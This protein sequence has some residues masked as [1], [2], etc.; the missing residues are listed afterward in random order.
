MERYANLS[1]EQI[2]IFLM[3]AKLENFSR[4]AAALNLT[5]SAVSKNIQVIENTTGLILF[6]RHQKRVRLTRAGEYLAKELEQLNNQAHMIF[7]SA[8]KIQQN[9]LLSVSVCSSNLLNNARYVI[10][11]INKFQ[12]SNV[13][14]KVTLNIMDDSAQLESLI[15]RKFDMGIVPTGYLKY[16]NQFGYISKIIFEDIPYILLAESHPLF[17][18]EPEDYRKLLRSPLLA[19]AD[20]PSF[21]HTRFQNFLEQLDIEHG[22]ITYVPNVYT[23]AA[24]LGSGKYI[25]ISYRDIQ[26][27]TTYKLKRVPLP[28]GEKHSGVAIVYD[29]DNDNPLISKLI[30]YIMAEDWI[31]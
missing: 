19:I 28:I 13:D 24:L 20:T 23:A 30:P 29:K 14:F 9:Q 1:F 16:L 26:L 3:T 15:Q 21:Y 11:A 8:Y 17:N 18:C 6:V 10:P 31:K 7:D 12:K 22:D 27:N 5:Q 4:A 25:F 2:R